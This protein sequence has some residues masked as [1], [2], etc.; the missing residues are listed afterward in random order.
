MPLLKF[1]DAE[2]A[3]I[4]TV[5]QL[6]NND[7]DDGIASCP[8]L[9]I[10]LDGAGLKVIH[11]QLHPP[12]GGPLSSNVAE[13]GNS[14]GFRIIHNHP[15]GA[16]LSDSDW[17]VL[18]NYTKC[19]MTAVNKEGTTFR[20]KVIDAPRMKSFLSQ[21]NKIITNVEIEQTKAIDSFAKHG[22]AY[23][24][25]QLVENKWYVSAAIAQYIHS[26][27][28]VEYELNPAGKNADFI[29]SGHSNFILDI[30]DSVCRKY[31]I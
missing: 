1:T 5:Y 21:Y 9:H 17:T 6:L 14:S 18:A 10:T 3:A 16:S 31:N 4:N 12:H 29:N 13:V 7:F 26:K 30:I 2:N 23:L 28:I 22:H 15:S 25:E 11:M 20:G 8:E 24:V 27:K 19:E